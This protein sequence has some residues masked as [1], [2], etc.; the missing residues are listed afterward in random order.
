MSLRTRGIIKYRWYK[1]RN[2]CRW[3]HHKTEINEYWGIYFGGVKYLFRY[4]AKSDKFGEN[5]YGGFVIPFG[6]M[7]L[8]IVRNY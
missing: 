7:T 2:W 4:R 3:F 1:I 6:R 5:D 8:I